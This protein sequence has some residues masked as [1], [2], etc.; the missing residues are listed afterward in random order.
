MRSSS[1]EHYLALDHIRAL[2][3]LMV[4]TWHFTHASTGFPISFDYSPFL[5]PFS[6][7]DE[8]HTGVAL[9]MT[10]SGYLFAKLLQGKTIDYR[11]FLWNRAIR[12]LPLLA[13][14]LLVNGAYL[15]FRGKTTLAYYV[16][17]IAAGVIF[18]SLPNGGWSITVEFHYYLI[19]P[20][21]LYMVKKS[22]WLP[23]SIILSSLVVRT[24]IHEETGEVQSLAY[25]TI[26]GRID[27]F[28]LGMLAFQLRSYVAK[29]H[30]SIAIC[31][32]SFLLFYWY[33]DA[34]G[35]F[36]A[37]PAYPSPSRLWIV[38]PTIEGL[39]YAIGIA[40]YDTSFSPSNE[41]FSKYVG[42][43]GAYS[44]SI[45]LLHYNVV[46]RTAGFINDHIMDLSNFYLACA[47]SV[48]CF[49][50][51]IPI[52]YLSFRFIEL[53]FLKYRKWYVDLSS[54]EVALNKTI[55][56]LNPAVKARPRRASNSP[57][58]IAATGIHD[59]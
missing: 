57:T 37:A 8:G 21:F 48:V 1:G 25:W 28:A 36:M 47:W 19:L 7:L 10:L 59:R 23:L 35:G 39:S 49:V 13:V 12:L 38:L 30:G 20:L 22:R 34:Q 24:L 32:I 43:A 42:Y 5:L 46:F 29:R 33:F 2:A 44:Y 51:M 55:P 54:K 9:F 18:P 17:T 4:F 58:P 50:A 31:L 52:G 11:A 16:Q 15:V 45:Y 3:A 53:P 6:L 26:I 41:G 40:W 56:S 14:V 27:Q